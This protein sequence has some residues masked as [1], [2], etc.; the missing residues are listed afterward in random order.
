M[1][2]INT[3]VENAL[4]PTKEGLEAIEQK[5]NVINNSLQNVPTVQAMQN[6]ADAVSRIEGVIIGDKFDKNGIKDRVDILWTERVIRKAFTT[7][8]NIGSLAG[9]IGLI[10]IIVELINHRL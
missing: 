3:I 10:A 6:I 4:K 9:I 2:Q 5:V 8:L 7:F 1:E